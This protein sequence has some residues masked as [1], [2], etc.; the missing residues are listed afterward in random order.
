MGL[1]SSNVGTVVVADLQGLANLAISGEAIPAIN[2]ILN[3]GVAIPTTIGPVKI[4]DLDIEFSAPAD[5]STPCVSIAANVNYTAPPSSAAEAHAA[6]DLSTQEHIDAA[7][8]KV[9]AGFEAALG[10][11]TVAAMRSPLR[12][13]VAS[14][15]AQLA[16]RV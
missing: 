12:S 11:A 9:H 2:K 1:I 7:A 4:Q 13:I 15:V 5:G 14:A 8:S 6:L 10:M 3:K 16:G